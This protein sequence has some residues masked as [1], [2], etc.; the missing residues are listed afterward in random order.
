M[1]DLRNEALSR[2]QE[3]NWLEISQINGFEKQIV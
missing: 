2:S 3:M 1:K